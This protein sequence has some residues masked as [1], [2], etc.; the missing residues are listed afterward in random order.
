MNWVGDV[1]LMVNIGGLILNENE[2]ENT[3]FLGDLYY[4]C[5]PITN[6]LTVCI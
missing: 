1:G 5:W 3:N 2:N 4:Y 6:Q